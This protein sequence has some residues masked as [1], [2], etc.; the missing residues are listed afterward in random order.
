MNGIIGM[1]SLLL[2]TPLTEEQRQF[3]QTVRDSAEALLA[4]LNDILDI[5]KLEAGRIDLETIDFDL[6]NVVESAIELMSPRAREKKIDIGA[7]IDPA[8]PQNYLGDPTRLRQVL[9]NLLGNAIKFTDQ[10]CVAVE[11]RREPDDAL[12][13][14]LRFEVIDTGIGI[15][16]ESRA[17]LFQKFTQADQSITR[18]FGGTG[19]GL[20]ISRQLV[21]LMGGTIG[22]ESQP[23]KGST[24]WFTIRLTPAQSSA[25][26]PMT[27][28]EQLRDRRVLVVDDTEM[29]RRIMELRLA[30]WGM[31][32]TCAEDGFAGFAEVER[33]WHKGQSY[34]LI[35]L[36]QMMPGMS[37][38][39]LTERVR[40]DQRFKNIKIVLASSL[41]ASE[42][43]RAHAD[44]YDAVLLK[45][46][47]HH[48]LMDSLARL[49][50]G[51]I[52]APRTEARPA[53]S[54]R[55]DGSG[56]ILLAEDNKVNQQ[57][58]L[59]MLRRAGY[60]V[61]TATNG[62]EAIAALRRNDYDL[63]L[64]DV[65]MPSMDG[66]EATR[67]IRSFEGPKA[68][69]PIVAMT[70]HAM[71]G[72][73]E[74]YLAAGMDDYLPKPLQREEFLAVVGKWAGLANPPSAP[75]EDDARAP[76]PARL[77][78]A[79]PPVFDDSSLAALAR[80]VSAEELRTLLKTYLEGAAD[81]VAQAETGAAA[82]DL[83]ALAKTAHDLVSTSGNFGARRVQALARRLEAACKSGEAAEVI[84]LAAGIRSA[85]EQAW[86]AIRDRFLRGAA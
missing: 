38:D 73:R 27:V 76:Q 74:Q 10:G 67:K 22:V 37:G 12:G 75:H 71:A 68:D 48:T 65:Q 31:H 80:D 2:D 53:P 42:G 58:A 9:L 85:S 7:Y 44:Q 33:A 46:V 18:R 28:P 83:G 11:V 4:I 57:I 81:L 56:R 20:S 39:M 29:N 19:L 3:A 61:D 1:N 32:V 43:G 16:K 45:P 51:P 35:V 24:F 62:L 41:G 30:G 82:G 79:D 50:G 49:F 6:H 59:T 47:R 17:K 86:A 84:T 5:A 25:A 55:R 23:G 34:D 21:E 8:V 60:V 54:P 77:D 15:S 13:N 69:V 63:I 66:I 70:A 14:L 64:M 52:V 26:P 40:N 36:D 72:A 78:E